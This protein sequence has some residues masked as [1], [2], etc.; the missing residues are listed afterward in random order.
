MAHHSG[1]AMVA[2][3]NVL[4]DAPMR[5]RLMA[6]PRLR[7]HDLLLQ[8]RMPQTVRPINWRQREVAGRLIA[9]LEGA[10]PTVRV[11]DAP[12]SA[13]DVHVLGGDGYRLELSAAG[14]SEHFCYLRDVTSGRFWSNTFEPTLRQGDRHKVTFAPGRAEFR[15]ICKQIDARTLVAVSTEQGLEV[16]RIKLSN[17]S[18]DERSIELTTFVE[19][20]QSGQVEIASVGGGAL[21]AWWPPRAVGEPTAWMYH[22]IRA[23][24]AQTTPAGFETSRGR[25]VGAGRTLASPAALDA[26]GELPGVAGVV[27]DAILSLRHI[28]ALAAEECIELDIVTGTAD[29]RDRALAAIQRHRDPR[30]TWRVFELADAA[31]RV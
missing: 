15:A 16:R 30:L 14:S 8:Q 1:M 13:Q 26:P 4:L 19:I 3:A 31:A 23:I 29:T 27:S 7:A 2:L 12:Q 24:D 11:I 22:Y 9:R 17:L 18:R 25:F 10:G 20:G 6:D 21:L 5:R 28:V